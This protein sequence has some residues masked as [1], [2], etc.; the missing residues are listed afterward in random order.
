[1][2]SEQQKAVLLMTFG[3]V[4]SLEEVAPFLENV[5]GGLK[6][7][8]RVV[9]E[10]KERYR[11]IGGRSPLREITLRQAQSLQTRLD[12]ICKGTYRVYTGMRYWHPYI[13]DTLHEIQDAGIDVVIAVIMA[14]QSSGYIARGYQADLDAAAK[15]LKPGIT[16]KLI[17]DWHLNRM[18]LEA[19]A[20]KILEGLASFEDR[21][22][23]AVIFSA[24]SLP[25]GFLEPSDRYVSQIEETI[26]GLT[27]ITGPLK[28]KLGYQSKGKRAGDWLEPDTGSIMEGLPEQGFENVLIVP[29]GFVADH[30]ETLYDIDIEYRRKAESIGLGFRR[31][32]SLNDTPK[33]I[34]ALRDIVLGR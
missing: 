2:M 17:V 8:Q 27:A 11:L 34:E 3:G 33:F 9:E 4:E 16:I 30:V 23:T 1:M 12:K 24:H 32:A 22:K 25:L 10:V 26:S 7:P 28:W 5:T 18:Y 13:M 6:P 15:E 14:P 29:V 31:T 19:I 20:E 21:Q